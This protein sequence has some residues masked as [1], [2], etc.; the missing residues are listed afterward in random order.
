M[1]KVIAAV[2]HAVAV[3]LEQGSTRAPALP[4]AA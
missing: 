2:V 1:I 4:E 3:T